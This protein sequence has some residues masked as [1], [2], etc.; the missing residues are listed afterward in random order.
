GDRD[1]GTRFRQQLRRGEADPV[2]GA[3]A[4]HQGDPTLIP[5]S[6][7]FHDSPILKSRNASSCFADAKLTTPLPSGRAIAMTLASGRRLPVVNTPA[8]P[9]T[10]S[11]RA[12]GT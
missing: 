3:G 10:P 6:L 2:G 11:R 4:G 8:S 1:L 9:Q 12:C 7:G 5:V